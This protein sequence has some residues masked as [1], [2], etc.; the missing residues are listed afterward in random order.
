MA[1]KLGIVIGRFQPVHKGHIRDVIAPACKN[2]DYVLFLLGSANR[3]TNS[4]NPFSVELRESM[5]RCVCQSLG[6]DKQTH[7]KFMG[8]NDYKYSDE[9]WVLQIQS[10]VT[11]AVSAIKYIENTEV[12]I[13]LYGSEKDSSSYYLGLF[14]QWKLALGNVNNV[15]IFN[16]TEVR[17]RLYRKDPCWQDLVP[18]T[19]I[20]W[21]K[22][23]YIG[24]ELEDTM[25]NEYNF[26]DKYKS[27][28]K[29]P[30]DIDNWLKAYD[31]NDND[32]PAM[33]RWSKEIFESLAK[34]SYYPPFFITVDA[35]VLFRGQVLLIKRGHQPGKGLWALSGGFLDH[36]EKLIDSAIRE[37]REETKFR[38]RKEW[39]KASQVFDDPDRS[40]RGRT[41]THAFL[42]VVPNDVPEGTIDH[43]MNAKYVQGSDDAA[44]AQW[45]PLATA[46]EAPEF[47]TGMFED[48]HEILQCMVSKA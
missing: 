9:R 44:H 12:E 16:A 30:I 20:K 35:V 11:Q 14:P 8:I 19:V 3:S 17:D 42:F 41:V 21:L 1:V 15:D 26:I 34:R 25:V 4:K 28:F 22:T 38:L 32:Y 27:Q 48:H 13:T 23:N 43:I 6:Y 47:V 29:R 7:L 18:D 33:I 40:L 36:R 2:S 39:L 46:L 45:V 10:K 24:S 5:I 31:L 37:V